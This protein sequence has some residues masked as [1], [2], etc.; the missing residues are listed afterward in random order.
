MFQND[1][2]CTRTRLVIVYTIHVTFQ[3]T[4]LLDIHMAVITLGSHGD[5]ADK[6][7]KSK[8]TFT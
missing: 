5:V 6:D 7:R 1:Y 8:M 2:N 3:I 4:F